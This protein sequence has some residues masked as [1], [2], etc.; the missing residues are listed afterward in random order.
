MGKQNFISA[1]N[2]SLLVSC[3]WTVGKVGQVL[4]RKGNGALIYT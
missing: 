4:I 1:L 3:L 2:L